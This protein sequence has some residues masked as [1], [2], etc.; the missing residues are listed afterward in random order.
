MSELWAKNRMP[1]YGYTHEIWYI[2]AH[3]LVKDQYFLYKTN[4]IWKVSLNCIVYVIYILIS[5]E[6]WKLRPQYPQK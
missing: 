4:F 6:M 2:S 1:I 5:I 3:K